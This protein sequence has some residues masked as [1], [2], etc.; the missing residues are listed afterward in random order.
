MVRADRQTVIQIYF[1]IFWSTADMIAILILVV[2]WCL[3][4]TDWVH[5]LPFF[6]RPIA[7]LYDKCIATD[8]ESIRPMGLP[9]HA[10]A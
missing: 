9:A 5:L 10:S 1:I 4:S 6:T 7:L 3:D 8:H 2:Y